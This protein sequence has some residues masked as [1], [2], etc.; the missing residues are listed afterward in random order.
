[1]R[2]EGHVNGDVH[3]GGFVPRP[4]AAKNAAALSTKTVRGA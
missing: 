4:A 3:D 1:V 2:E